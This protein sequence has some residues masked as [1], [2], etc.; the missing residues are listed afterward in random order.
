MARS[1]VIPLN[2][3]P[4]VLTADAGSPLAAFF[5]WLEKVLFGR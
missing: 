4:A 2:L 5:L 1:A 3:H